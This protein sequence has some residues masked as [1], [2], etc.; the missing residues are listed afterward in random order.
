M[1]EGLD[2]KPLKI[3]L[4]NITLHAGASHAERKQR[5]HKVAGIFACF[6]WGISR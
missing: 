4:T 2:G 6:H 3:G 5:S 1:S